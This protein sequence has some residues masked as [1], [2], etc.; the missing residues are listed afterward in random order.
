M[1]YCDFPIGKYRALVSSS[2]LDAFKTT[3]QVDSNYFYFESTQPI[4]EEILIKSADVAVAHHYYGRN[5]DN[6]VWVCYV[7][8]NGVLNVKFCDD[9]FPTSRWQTYHIPYTIA[10]TCSLCFDAQLENDRQRSSN[11]Y[12]FV[13][14]EIPW[15]CYT[16]DNALYILD[17]RSGESTLIAAENVIDVSLVRGPISLNNT[18]DLGLIA[19]FLMENKVYYKQMIKGVWYDAEVVTSTS[20]PDN[21]NYVRIEAF[22]TWDFRIGLQLIDEDGQMYQLISYFEGLSNLIAENISES[23]VIDNASLTGITYTDAQSAN[24]N[25]L[26]GADIFTAVI[27]AWSA[28][29]LS[30]VNLEDE[31]NN[32]GTTIQVVFDY[33]NTMDNLQTSSFTLIDANTN[34]FVC[35]SAVLSQNGY[36]LT[37][38]F[39]D[40]NATYRAVTTTLTY[41]KPASGGLI[42]P[43]GGQTDTFA[44]TF[45][46]QNLVDPGPPPA[47]LSIS[48]N[49]SG[50][51]IYIDFDKSFLNESVAEALSHFTVTILG[52]N[53][54]PEGT[55]M[56]LSR[57]ISSVD[58]NG[59]DDSI[60]LTLSQNISAA[61][62]TNSVIVAYDGAGGLRG[63]G[64]PASAFTESFTP[65]GLTYKGDQN[66]SE[67][68]LEN[69]TISATL[70]K[71]YYTSVQDSNSDTI[72]ENATISTALIDVHDI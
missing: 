7:K 68:I 53:H 2:Y 47:V 29:P 49:A 18:Y 40:F 70:T 19:F 3:N 28:L 10:D 43:A 35:R 14:D 66:D 55:L 30:V 27:W 1:E 48:N 51:E 58:F 11:I 44:L 22:R 64:G 72:S 56:N 5:G 57:A 71:I 36:V 38:T 67:N 6:V 12:E 16:R 20:L 4:D 32:W 62:G 24:D 42:S 37:L 21:V 46:P 50:T 61:V 69:A 25:V 63:I 15:I 17:L 45:T 52:Y 13:T 31:N 54:V 8:D 39:D 26:T 59:S 60:V 41:T 65:V 23:A 34:N 9:I 33:P